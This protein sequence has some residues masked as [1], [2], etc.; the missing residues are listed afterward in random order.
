MK[1][2]REALFSFVR[3]ERGLTAVETL[4]IGG[5]LA[6]IAIGAYTILRPFVQNGAQTLGGKMQNAIGSN[7]PTW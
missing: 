4:I 1:R 7:N 2:L 6:V 3:D 5:I